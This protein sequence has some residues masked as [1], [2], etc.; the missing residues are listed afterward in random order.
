MVS[1]MLNWWSPI[2]EEVRGRAFNLTSGKILPTQDTYKY[3]IQVQEEE[4]PPLQSNGTAA[5][6]TTGTAVAKHGQ[7][8][9]AG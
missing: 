1:S 9:N 5:T 4:H 3:H 7:D 2:K 6:S 8:D